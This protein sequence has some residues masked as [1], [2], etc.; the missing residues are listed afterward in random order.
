MTYVKVLSLA[1]S[2]LVALAALAGTASATTLTSPVNTTYTGTLKLQSSSTISLTSVFGGWGKLNCTSSTIESS[3]GSHGAGVTV[4]G[5]ISTLTFS[6]CNLPVT[7]VNKG[8]L[9]LHRVNDEEA[10][11]T[12]KGATITVHMTLFG[13]CHFIASGTGTGIGTLTTTPKTGGNAVLD[14]S[15]TLQSENGCGTGTW[16]GSYK[17][18]TPASLFIDA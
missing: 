11:L 8:S 6:A 7:V 18:V 16:E 3:V 5:N 13:T 14:T 9:E 2:V 10:A 1:A 12:A 4:S 17:V 15:G